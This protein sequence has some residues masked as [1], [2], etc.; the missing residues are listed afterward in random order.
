[1]MTI[2]PTAGNIVVQPLA[3]MKREEKGGRD[4]G[5]RL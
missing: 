5:E 1:M 2:K 3:S 4:E